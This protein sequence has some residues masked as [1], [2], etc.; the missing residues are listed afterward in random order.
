MDFYKDAVSRESAS[1]LKDSV[2]EH[3][4]PILDYAVLSGVSTSTLRRYIKAK[5]IRYKI[6][7]GRY[8]LT[9][10]AQLASRYAQQQKPQSPIQQIRNNW[11]GVNPAITT[12]I[13]PQ[14]NHV[15][16]LEEKLLLAQE[17]INELQMLVATYEEMLAK[18]DR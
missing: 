3:W 1:E 6:E 15:R 14:Q 8:L 11:D 18:S 5:K 7:N 17:Q 9:A 16:D 2:D 10:N 13:D 12:Y 4:I